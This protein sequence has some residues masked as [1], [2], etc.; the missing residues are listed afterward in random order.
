MLVNLDAP[1]DVAVAPTGAG[2]A[3]AGSS[4]GRRA[5]EHAIPGK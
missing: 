5:G 2:A 1:D 3:L 4:R